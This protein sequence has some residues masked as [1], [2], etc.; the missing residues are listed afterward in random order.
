MNLNAMQRMRLAA[1]IAIAALAASPFNN[2]TGSRARAQDQFP[3]RLVRIVAPYPPG[4]QMDI[5]ARLI[6]NGLA[7]KWGQPVIVENVIGA[8]GN[9]GS[10]VAFR[11]NPDGYTLMVTSPSFVTNEF[12]YKKMS[13]T[14]SQMSPIGVLVTT[15]YVLVA[16]KD[17]K[18][19]TVRDLI[20]LARQKA[21]AI[22]YASN[23][24]GSSAHLSAIQLQILSAIEMLH[25]PYKG[26]APA[27]T[28]L[29]AGRV[30]VYFD[31]LTTALPPWRDQKI[32][33]LGVTS[34]TRSRFA[35]DIPTL[36][37]SGAPRFESMS[38]A[39]LMAPPATPP[40]IV[41]KVSDSVRELLQ[42]QE[43]TKVL[44]SLEM[45]VVAS[46]PDQTKE[47][48]SSESVRWKAILAKSGIALD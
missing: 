24:V 39:G 40:A 2:T 46:T 14:P 11:A 37:E 19:T 22:S 7:R 35:P 41:K 27:M 34:P 44:T 15:P 47:Y 36:A 10:A 45:D 17:I 6:A 33:V 42:D 8:G 28:D 18:A 29:I 43:T 31:A 4:G 16:R 13:W 48:L 20:E 5:V 23:G 30:D 12:V 32:R 9:L 26:A 1:T 21:Q 38:W 25:V 3:S